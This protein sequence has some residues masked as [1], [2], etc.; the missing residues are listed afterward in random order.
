MSNELMTVGSQALVDGTWTREKLDL[1]KRTIC[2]D[3]TD[4]EF[5]LFMGAVK[6][7]GFDPFLRQIH[8]VKRWDNRENRY[9]MAIQVGI[10]GFR[11]TAERSGKYAGSDDAIFDDEKE[12]AR[13][14]VTVW[15]L[16]DGQR[17]AFTATAR[18]DEYYPGDKQGF[19]WKAKPC[20]MLGKCA[21]AQ[22]LRKAFPAEL[23]GLYAPEELELK[24]KAGVAPNQPQPEDGVQ[25]EEYCCSANLGGKFGRL[26]LKRVSEADPA[27][28]REAVQ[29]IEE[30]ARGLALKKND[31][32][33]ETFLPD[34]AVEFIKQAEPYIARFEN[35]MSGEGSFADFEPGSKE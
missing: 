13:A 4:D 7:T 16:L 27:L 34:W 31:P 14:T 9:V 32:K 35:N 33:W 11:L 28:M 26:R 19:M 5:A 3:A 2:K 15:K 6:R 17:C 24:P 1:L 21:E 18:W 8:A 30:K 23:S 29:A 12:P 25:S 10:D 22:A 20:V